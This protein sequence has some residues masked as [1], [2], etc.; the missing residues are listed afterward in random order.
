MRARGVQGFTFTPPIS[1]TTSCPYDSLVDYYARYVILGVL[2][3][4]FYA[5]EDDFA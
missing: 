5:V 1:S 2:Y 4:E 3:Y